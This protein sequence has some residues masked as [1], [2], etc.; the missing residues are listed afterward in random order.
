MRTLAGTTSRRRTWS[1][2]GDLR[3]MPSEYEI[4]THNTNWT[5]RKGRASALEASP[6]SPAN[7]WFLTYRDRSP[8]HVEDWNDFRDP[9][10][11]TYRRY[12]TMQ[13]EQETVVASLLEEYS[14]AGHDKAHPPAWR[15]CLA[16]LF[17]PARY[18][19]HAMQMAYAYLA[20]MAPSS[21]ISN[22]AAFATA[23]MLR[24]VS[25]TAY[26]TR[27]LQRTWPKEGFGAA[28]RTI[29]ETEPAWQEARKALELSLIAYDW[30]ECFCAINLVLRPSM[31]H[32]LNYQLGELARRNN[33]EQTWLLL[34]NLSLDSERCDRWTTALAT[35]AIDRCPGNRDVFQRWVAKWA[36]RSD[37]AVAGLAN[38]MCGLANYA[39]SESEIASAARSRRESLLRLSGIQRD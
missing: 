6:S 13:D 26:R 36:P 17:A 9:D 10:E 23:D 30:A 25:L 31:E 3:R 38:L 24:R 1:N 7:L 34:S 20:H 22:C 5:L 39:A 35:F 15:G 16:K 37:S 27:E 28:E 11:V 29:W 8:L 18:S 14:D 21:Y 12:V 4:V 19:A 32:V 2:F 33:D